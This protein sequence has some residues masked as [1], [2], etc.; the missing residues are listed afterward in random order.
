[1][2]GFKI[3]SVKD[4][5]DDGKISR[6]GE[7]VLVLV[8]NIGQDSSKAEVSINPS[9]VFAV[10]EAPEAQELEPKG[11][12][13]FAFRLKPKTMRSGISE[14][15]VFKVKN[16]TSTTGEYDEESERFFTP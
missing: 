9:E 3:I 10:V 1:M 6:E 7:K 13:E 4:E 8:Q 2:N 16:L 5:N 15:L 14:S 12:L 11:E